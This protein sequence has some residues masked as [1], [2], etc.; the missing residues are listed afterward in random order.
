MNNTPVS[1]KK[2]KRPSSVVKAQLKKDELVAF[3]GEQ[4]AVRQWAPEAL[5]W[6][7]PTSPDELPQTEAD[8]DSEPAVED[9]AAGADKPDVS[10]EAPEAPV[11]LAA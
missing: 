2:S 9:A 1:A 3:V 7:M 11:D 6:P 10:A 5:A 4:A 8:A